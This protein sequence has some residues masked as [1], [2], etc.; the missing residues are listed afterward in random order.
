MTDKTISI[1]IYDF[2]V[3]V[4]VTDNDDDFE[5]ATF[6]AGYEQDVEGAGM[7]VFNSGYKHY[8]L[9]VLTEAV[10]AGNIAHEA[11]HLSNRIWRD[12]GAELTYTNDEPYAYLLGFTTDCITKI[13]NDHEN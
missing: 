5:Q 3:R 13:I 6:D 10:S 7:I 8:T 12:I 9:G 4:I 11:T 1:P 2:S